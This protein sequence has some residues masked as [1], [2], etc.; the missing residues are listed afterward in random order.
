MAANCYTKH[1][2]A[3]SDN[4]VKMKYDTGSRDEP[5]DIP[6]MGSETSHWIYRLWALKR[7][8]EK[9]QPVMGSETSHWIY[10]LRAQRQATGYTGYGRKIDS[11][12][13]FVEGI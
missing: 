12:D 1:E 7:A 13:T 5:L 8:T 2:F 6:V 10:R 4:K 9:Y 11:P 3:F